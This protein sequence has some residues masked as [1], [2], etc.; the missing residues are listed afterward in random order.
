MDW[1]LLYRTTRPLIIDQFDQLGVEDVKE[2][3]RA[4][5]SADPGQ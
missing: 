5:L 3:D 4:Y 2:L 1:V